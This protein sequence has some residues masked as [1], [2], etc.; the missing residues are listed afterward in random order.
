LR[1]K[2]DI[3]PALVVFD[4]ESPQTIAQK[5]LELVRLA[6]RLHYENCCARGERGGNR[7]ASMGEHR[8]D[9]A[10]LPGRLDLAFRNAAFK[11]RL[12]R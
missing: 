4:S 2:Q 9:V 7:T 10:R 8:T 1:S 6:L 11:T 5:F 12:S 3:C